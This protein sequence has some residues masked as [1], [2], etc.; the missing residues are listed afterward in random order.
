MTKLGGE[1]GKPQIQHLDIEGQKNSGRTSCKNQFFNA[2]GTV[3]VQLAP[4]HFK[5]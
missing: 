5:L 2:F 1:G 4:L 3:L